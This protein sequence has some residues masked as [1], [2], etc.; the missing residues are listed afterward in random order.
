MTDEAGPGHD[1][2]PSQRRSNAKIWRMRT[3]GRFGRLLPPWFRRR[4]WLLAAAAL[5]GALGGLSY[6]MVKAPSY[7]AQ[8][9]L[10]VPAGR[11][12]P[13]PATHRTRRRWP[14]RMPRF[15]RPTTRSLP[16]LQKN[17]ACLSTA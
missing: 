4:A 15:C 17:W 11:Q 5:A 2:R 10:A 16:P 3:A 6:G 9:V 1:G 13:S 7:S 14:S 8:A 12:A